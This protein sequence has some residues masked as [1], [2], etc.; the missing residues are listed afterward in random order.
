MN[1]APVRG[2]LAAVIFLTRL[3]LPQINFRPAD[4]EWATAHFPLVGAGIGLLVGT[5]VV[6]ASPLLGPFAAAVLAV[7]VGILVTGAFHEDGLADS[8]DALGGGIDD[9]AR[10]LA[11]LKDSRIG[12]YGAC[13]LIITIALRVAL[14]A[15]LGP[16]VVEALI[17]AHA[18]GRTPPV[19][20][21]TLLPY[22]TSTDVARSRDL[23]DSGRLQ[24]AIALL[25]ALAFGVWLA[26]DPVVL[27]ILIVALTALGTLLAW[28]FRARVGG[29][30]GDFLG[31]T[32]QLSELTILVVLVAVQA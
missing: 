24:L 31:A 32:E 9:K 7:G 21:K 2:V 18:L 11:I 1:L 15:R 14:I 23:A 26:P 13:A 30:T 6:A 25:W 28:R 27:G 4:W 16:Q 12:T 29:Y 8:A 17:L 3:P 20:L 22:A 5:V 19:V 10:V